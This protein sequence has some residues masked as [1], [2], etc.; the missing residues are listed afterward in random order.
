MNAVGLE[1]AFWESLIL[2][3][4]ETW[5][6]SKKAGLTWVLQPVSDETER[7]EKVREERGRGEGLR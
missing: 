6:L 1:T 4:D 3:M 2:K 5:K 7:V